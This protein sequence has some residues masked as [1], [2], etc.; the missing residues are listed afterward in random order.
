MKPVPT[1][2]SNNITFL[3]GRVARL[4]LEA[5]EQALAPLKLSVRDFNMLALLAGDGPYSQ[6]ALATR[7]K[8]D[9]QTMK[10]LVDGLEERDLLTR[11]VDEHDR[12]SNL[13]YITVKGKKVHAQAKR[14][15]DKR[16]K[17][18]LSALS[19]EEWQQVQA[20]LT[21]LIESRMP[22]EE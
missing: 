2:L 16:Q 22:E 10:E 9:K 8:V 13:L 17:E 15:S 7:Y 1:S 6:Q 20:S 14:L 12:R 4:A 21:K 19:P 5:Y 18:F 11:V 3:F